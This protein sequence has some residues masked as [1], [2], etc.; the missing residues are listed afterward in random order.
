MSGFPCML[1]DQSGPLEPQ[2]GFNRYIEDG[3]SRDSKSTRDNGPMKSNERGES[4]R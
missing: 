2:L 1:L 3:I 4:G